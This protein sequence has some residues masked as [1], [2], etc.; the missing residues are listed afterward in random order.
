M[1]LEIVIPVA[2]PSLN[3]VLAM[4]HFERKKLRDLLHLFVSL[5]IT[6]G[7]AWP[8]ST[9]FME[10]ACSTDLLL[11]EYSALT[12]PSKS[13]RSLLRRLK[14]TKSRPKSPSKHSTSVNSSIKPNKE[15]RPW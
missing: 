12:R 4:H 14:G 11:L 2:M 5:S 8:T 7:N 9:I 13:R 1:K 10:K 3:R 6:H 15:D